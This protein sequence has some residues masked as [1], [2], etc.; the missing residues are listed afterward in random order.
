MPAA[1][2]ISHPLSDEFHGGG[3]MLL[4]SPPSSPPPP[5]V[6]DQDFLEHVVSRMDTL[7]GIAIKYG[8]EVILHSHRPMV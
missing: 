2:G 1:M 8:V 6:D 4:L 5:A 7:A 3:G